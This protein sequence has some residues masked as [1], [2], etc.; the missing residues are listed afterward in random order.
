M[1]GAPG[2]A[3]P[4]LVKV[5]LSAPARPTLLPLCRSRSWAG[6]GLRD[7]P[8]GA[9]TAEPEL[10]APLHATGSSWRKRP[11]DKRASRC[12]GGKQSSA[13]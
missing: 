8:L 3:T 1:L 11:T 5:L 12:V 7:A 13:L 4:F 9:E 6:A 2:L 10:A